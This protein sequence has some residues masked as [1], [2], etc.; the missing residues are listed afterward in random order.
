MQWALP[1]AAGLVV[2][3]DGLLPWTT[4]E[5]CRKA[6]RN[7]QIGLKRET[8]STRVDGKSL[9]EWLGF[10]ARRTGTLYA[11]LSARS[12]LLPRYAPI[13][14]RHLI[15]DDYRRR[16]VFSQD[17]FKQ[18]RIQVRSATPWFLAAACN[19]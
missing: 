18:G 9:T 2:L 4:R 1:T 10:T 12:D 15:N 11:A 8:Q 14:G 17:V 16:R 3:K 6:G 19:T 5:S 13:V 7:K